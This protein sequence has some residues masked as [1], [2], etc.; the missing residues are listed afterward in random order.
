MMSFRKERITLYWDKEF[1]KD[2]KKKAID[3]DLKTSEYIR[4]KLLNC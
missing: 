4:R 2:I 1:I 3:A